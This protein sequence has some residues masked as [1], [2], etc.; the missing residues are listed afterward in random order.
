MEKLIQGVKSCL[1]DL[2]P[3]SVRV[4]AYMD[5]YTPDHAPLV[6]FLPGNENII[7]MGGF[8][9]HGFK[10]APL[11]GRIASELVLTGETHYDIDF[12]DPAR[13]LKEKSSL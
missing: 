6:G 8:S 4:A 2:I 7:V 1:P 11:M 12:M 5:G 3:E 10:F 9:G 13:F